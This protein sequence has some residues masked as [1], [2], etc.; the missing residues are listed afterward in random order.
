MRIFSALIISIVILISCSNQVKKTDETT[1]KQ[2]PEQLFNSP[3]DTATFGEGCFWCIEPMYTQLIGI[4]TVIVGYSGG[5]VKNPTYQ[6]VSSGTTGH[7][8]VAQIIYD[9][10]Q[11]SYEQLLEVFF[12]SHDPTTLNQQG[13]DMGTQYRSV[14]FYHNEKQK[15]EAEEYLKQLKQSDTYKE[16]IVTAIEPFQ[17]FY[18]AE[19]YH[20]NY[21]EKNPNK[22][23][24]L[25]ETRPRVNQFEKDFRELIKKK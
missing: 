14:I 9:P 17:T 8:E 6:E 13:N 5:T 22:P 15:E 24:S 18:T 19:K 2:T 4:D 23:Y 10:S 16:P 11:L 12:K 20:Q 1:S 25:Y 7:V 3:K 21:Y